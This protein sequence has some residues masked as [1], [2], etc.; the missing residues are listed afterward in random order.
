MT[1]YNH[2]RSTLLPVEHPLVEGQL[3]EIDEQLEMGISQLNW[4]SEGKQYS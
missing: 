4:T 3:A 2:V 1:L